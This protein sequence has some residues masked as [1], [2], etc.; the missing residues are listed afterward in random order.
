[1]KAKEIRKYSDKELNKQIVELKKK[2][3]NLRFQHAVGQLEDTAQIRKT[4]K[5]IAVMNTIISER[6]KEV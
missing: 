6:K 2:L 5:Q 4:R 1:M 3:F